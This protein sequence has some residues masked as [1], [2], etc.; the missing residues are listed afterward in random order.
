[1]VCWAVPGS[2]VIIAL[3]D[4]VYYVTDKKHVVNKKSGSTGLARKAYSR[5]PCFSPLYLELASL[6]ICAPVGEKTR[7]LRGLET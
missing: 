4:R 1:M 3:L 6:K 7:N 2:I 5:L